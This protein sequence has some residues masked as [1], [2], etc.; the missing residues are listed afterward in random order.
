MTYR[1]DL[2]G[3]R[4]V[5]ILG[6]MVGHS[7][8]FWSHSARGLG[9]L[10]GVNLFFVL[11]GYLITTLL[12]A[13]REKTGRVSRPMFYARR[14][15]RLGP[16]LLLALA[17][18][19]LIAH[20]IGQP[21]F[22]GD[23]TPYPR[24]ALAALFF[25]GN[26]FKQRLGLLGHTWSL[27]VEEQYYLVWPT[28]LLIVTRL[29]ARRKGLIIGLVI[30][31]AGIAVMRFHVTH[32]PPLQ[33]HGPVLAF[34]EADGVLLGSAL[35]MALQ[36]EGRFSR[37]LRN[38]ALALALI[39]VVCAVVYTFPSRRFMTL[40]I[41]TVCFVLLIGHIVC[42]ENGPIS[43][44]LRV[45]PLPAIG[46]ISYGLYLY[47]FMLFVWAATVIHDRFTAVAAAWVLSIGA[48]TAS[49]VAVERPVLRYKDRFTPRRDQSKLARDRL[50]D[51]GRPAH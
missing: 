21:R 46:R 38:R 9:G 35:A 2:D 18:G 12:L 25:A 23:V 39:V 47:H 43:S 51:V 11:S 32:D 10:F 40:T 27:G 33:L 49:F 22:S 1:K 24:A 15:L 17:L 34:E 31:A 5:A 20:F 44:I 19:A 45:Q 4:A 3:V 41:A 16:A 13:E 30:V 26:W 50:P 8:L 36:R 6:V 48:A 7:V 14:A 28:V 42:C 37:F 29:G